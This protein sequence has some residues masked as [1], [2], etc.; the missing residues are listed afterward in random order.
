VQGGFT[1]HFIDG[2]LR[3]FEVV[4]NGAFRRDCGLFINGRPLPLE[5]AADGGFPPLAVRFRFQRLY[6]CLH[7]AIDPHMP[8][9][10]IVRTPGGDRAF[11]LHPD[12]HRFD[13][14]PSPVAEP[15]PDAPPWRG[16]QRPTDLTI[17]L[18]ID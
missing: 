1:S 10:L 3:R 17:D 5:P 14:A 8:L 12:G 9:E 15:V 6:P 11:Q 13:P 16:R 4:A 18:R 7:P 2:S